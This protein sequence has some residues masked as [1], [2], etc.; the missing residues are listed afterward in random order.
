MELHGKTAL[1]TGGALRVGRAIALTLAERGA[2]VVVN[3]NR[4]ADAANNTVKEIEAHG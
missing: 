1:V 4:S 2:N 3:Y